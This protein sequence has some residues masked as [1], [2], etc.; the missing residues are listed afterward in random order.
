MKYLKR[1]NENNNRMVKTWEGMNKTQRLT[2]LVKQFGMSVKEA[3][4]IYAPDIKDL[5]KEIRGYFN[6]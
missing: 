2:F 6:D 1:F 3:N 5:P 4:E